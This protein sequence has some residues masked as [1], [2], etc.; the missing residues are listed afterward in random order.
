MT[1]HYVRRFRARDDRFLSAWYEAKASA[2]GLWLSTP[3][4]V[5]LRAALYRA[6]A[7]HSDRELD[8][9]RIFVSTGKG[10]LWLRFPSEATT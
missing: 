7:D 5:R 10:N 9:G 4:P 8:A 6:R 2:F 1:K 3:D